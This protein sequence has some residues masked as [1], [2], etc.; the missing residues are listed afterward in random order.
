MIDLKKKVN[1]PLGHLFLPFVQLAHDCRQLDEE[2]V[3]AFQLLLV[4]F[5]DVLRMSDGRAR[6]LGILKIVYH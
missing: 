3:G 1:H 6:Y 5:P 2:S 4:Q